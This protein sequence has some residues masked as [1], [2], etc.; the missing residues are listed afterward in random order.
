MENKFKCP[1]CG[2][3]GKE[4]CNN[5]DHGFLRYVIGAIKSANESACPCCGH[6]EDHKIFKY[7]DGKRVKVICYECSGKGVVNDLIVKKYW[8]NGI[9]IS[10]QKILSYKKAP[11]LNPRL[12]LNKLL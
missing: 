5:P 6:D 2:G 9:L 1:A 4:T 8:T 3:D 7:V 10:R 12:P 11:K